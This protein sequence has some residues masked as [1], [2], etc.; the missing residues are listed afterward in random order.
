M[1]YFNDSNILIHQNRMKSRGPKW[2]PWGT[3]DLISK[4]LHLRHISLLSTAAEV[5]LNPTQSIAI[6]Y[7]ES[8]CK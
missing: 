3:P 7:N 2:L 6:Y 4:L 1:Q 8:Q 5:K